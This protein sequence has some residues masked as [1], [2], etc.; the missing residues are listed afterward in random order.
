[1]PATAARCCVIFDLA[2]VLV[3]GLQSMTGEMAKVFNI[4]PET[5]LSGLHGPHMREYNCGRIT[6]DEYWERVLQRSGWRGDVK[7]AK[8]VL[9]RHFSGRIPGTAEVLRE[10]A[11]RH[12]VFLLSD[13]GREW[14]ADLTPHH[15]FFKLFEKR[16]FSFDLGSMKTDRCTFEKVLAAIGA[17]AAECLFI[18]DHRPNIETAASAGIAGIVFTGAPALRSELLARGVLTG[19]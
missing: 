8:I 11:A 12:R 4:P 17:P 15:E 19:S 13:H 14:I 5:V 10:V 6:E 1:M 7:Q 2:E 9:R 3:L 16:F 18:D